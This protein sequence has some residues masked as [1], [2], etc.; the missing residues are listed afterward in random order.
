MPVGRLPAAAEALAPGKR[1]LLRVFNAAPTPEEGQRSITLATAALLLNVERVKLSFGVRYYGP[2]IFEIRPE[3]L[4]LERRLDMAIAGPVADLRGSWASLNDTGKLS[5][6][7]CAGPFG[8]WR[9][10]LWYLYHHAEIGA[11]EISA[12]LPPRVAHVK[13]TRGYSRTLRIFVGVEHFDEWLDELIGWF[14]YGWAEERLAPGHVRYLKPLD[15][16]KADRER[17]K[18]LPS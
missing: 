1:T 2:E 15:W 5:T 18:G 7:A 13:R 16:I 12:S 11:L 14:A 6:F 3:A 8:P 10:L 9:D 4:K 17:E